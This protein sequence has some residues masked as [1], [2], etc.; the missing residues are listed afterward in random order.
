MSLQAAVAQERA[1]QTD[2]LQLLQEKLG[3]TVRD[4]KSVLPRSGSLPP[5]PRS[6]E[7]NP[8]GGTLKDVKVAQAVKGVA[9][10]LSDFEAEV[11]RLTNLVDER[12]AALEKL[13][14]E[15]DASTKRSKELET[16]EAGAKERAAAALADLEKERAAVKELEGKM[17]ELQKAV[18]SAESARKGAGDQRA[19]LEKRVTELEAQVGS[20]SQ[21]RG[22]DSKAEVAA[23]QEELEEA[24]GAIELLNIELLQSS[25]RAA[26]LETIRS[27]LER[28]SAE[29][30]NRV[31]GLED[32]L[33]R[34]EADTE[35]AIRFKG[36]LEAEL[37][38]AKIRVDELETQAAESKAKVDETDFLRAELLEARGQLRLL[39]KEESPR[40]RQKELDAVKQELHDARGKVRNLEKEYAEERKTVQVRGAKRRLASRNLLRR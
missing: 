16:A 9:S 20:E 29:N 13:T 10:R 31:S 18:E 23:L 30:E 26:E 19:V 35:E 1:S 7:K 12:Q 15:L 3:D 39:A 40:A 24:K 37:L 14:A 2:T 33:K 4:P 27:E 5:S 28:V 11:L 38:A 36:E 21:K 32:R 6:A 34:A 17:G 22:D 8:N 25:G